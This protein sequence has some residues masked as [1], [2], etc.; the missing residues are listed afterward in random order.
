MQQFFAHKHV[1][2]FA[3]H[4]GFRMQCGI[5]NVHEALLETLDMHLLQVDINNNNNN[6]HDNVYGAVIMT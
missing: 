6:N 4:T 3:D 1:V 2:S 5:Q